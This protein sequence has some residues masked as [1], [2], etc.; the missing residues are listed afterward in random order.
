MFDP[1]NIGLLWED[2]P[3]VK[4]GGK[5][6]PR[7]RGPMPSIPIT[8][9][10][11]V[12]DFPNLSGSRLIGFDVE[13]YDPELTKA[14]PGWG[15]GK[16]HLIGASLAAEDGTAWYFPFGHG[17]DENMKPC[18]PPEEMALNMDYAQVMRY[19]Q[20]TL[21]T[22]TPKTGANLIY[23]VGA[24]QAE[25]VYVK[26][27]LYDI[28]FGAAL[29]DSEAPKVELDLLAQQYLGTGKVTETLYEWL[30]TW[31]GGPVSG[32]QRANL[33]LSPPSLAG[34]YAEAD[35]G[36]PV[37][38]LKKMWDDLHARGV[39]DLFQMECELIPLLVAMRM[40][41]APIDLDY[42]ERFHDELGDD[43]KVVEDR[44][45]EVA[46]QAVNPAARDSLVSAF[47]RAGLPIPTKKDTKTKETKVSFD[48]PT[49]EAM[50]GHPLIDGILEYRRISKVRNTFVKSYLIDKNVNGRIHCSF[51]P[52]KGSGGG[53][54]SGRFSSSDPNLQNIPTRTE[55]GRRV[56]EAFVASH[57]GRWISADYSQ[58]EYRMLAHHA[59]GP[60]AEELRNIFINDPNADYHDVTI[61]LI[62]KL[63]GIELDR[64]PAKN[65]N[66]GLIYGMSEMKLSSDLGLSPAQGRELFKNYHA[67]APYAM[68]TMEAAAEEV[69]R[70][71]YV[72]TILGRKS[73]FSRWG[74]KKSKE[75]VPD[76][77]Y[78]LAVRKWGTYNIQRTRTH[79]A[80][81]RKLQGG[82]ADV[83]KKA[84]L[85]AYKAGLFAEDA[86]G[87]PLLTVH[88]ELDFD[89]LNDPNGE[90][91]VEFKRIME[92]A[93]PQLRIPIVMDIE[94]G[95]NWGNCKQKLLAA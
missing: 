38:I 6:G 15:R 70:L 55:L 13:G 48:A 1:T 78:E 82:A 17:Y 65:I 79:K 44:L 94:Y 74:P 93:V 54:R 43:L 2:L 84:M 62:K 11:P 25:G 5:R 32:K 26:G 19:L 29:L 7:Q 21:G 42:C 59:V 46:G 14:G 64:K 92:N 52:L 76:L 45:K 61:A 23:D 71:G 40:K 56:R 30:A 9:W 72:E 86:C 68:A 24:L 36:Q 47:K 90:H 27:P 22:E 8:N 51:H 34:P 67:A 87:I 91:W 81:N 49:L 89:D 58:I 33:F 85:E 50:G 12:T 63:C 83:M 53:T 18:L 69:H 31:C 95:P 3:P 75:K 73:D 28:Q 57:G 66:F 35:A 16:S 39:L 37:L 41:G 20:H 88:D 80:L 10:R 60:M 77:P 4:K